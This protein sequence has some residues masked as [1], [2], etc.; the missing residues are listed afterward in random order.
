MGVKVPETPEHIVEE[1]QPFG[2]SDIDKAVEIMQQIYDK[3]NKH[4]RRFFEDELE[5]DLE[6]F[7]K[8]VFY[9][10][11]IQRGQSR[12]VESS[13]FSF[14]GG[15]QDESGQE[16][17]IRTVGKFKG[18]IEITNPARKQ[19]F[20][21]E[22]DELLKEIFEV[23]SELY[24]KKTGEHKAFDLSCAETS[25]DKATFI[26]DCDSMGFKMPKLVALIE[27]ISFA[28]MIK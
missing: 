7:P 9:T 22:K 17:T 15:Q 18:T 6:I 28:G 24:Q 5:H 20:E 10:A 1:K 8:P 2:E 13:W 12:G 19:K 11:E 3:T 16:S 14:G 21:D 27:D 4:Y 23:L 25:E 26:A